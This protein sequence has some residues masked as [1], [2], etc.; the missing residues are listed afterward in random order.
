VAIIQRGAL[1]AQGTIDELLKPEVQTVEVELT[2]VSA[3]LRAALDALAKAVRDAAPQVLVT[4]EGDGKV[5]ELLAL[6][7]QHGAQVHSVIP[8][9]ETL[10][11][12]FVRNDERRPEGARGRGGAGAT[13]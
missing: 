9:R 7:A 2:A 10:E 11:D 6:A 13:T 3:E 4:L 5:P 8:H 12:V 1:V